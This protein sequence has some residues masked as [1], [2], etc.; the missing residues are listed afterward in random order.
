MTRKVTSK[1]VPDK[2]KTPARTTRTPRTP[3]QAQAPA[4]VKAQAARKVQAS[5]KGQAGKQVKATARQPTLPA[6]PAPTIP[7]RIL[8][9]DIGGTH[10]KIL[11]SGQAVTQARRFDSG[12]GLTPA[13]MVAGVLELAKGWD[14]DAVSL[15]YPGPVLHGQ[16]VREPAN[17]AKGWVGFDYAGA[18]GKPVKIINDA[19]MQALGDYSGGKM[20]FLGLG[21][22][23]GTAL[24][25]DGIVEPLELAHLPYKKRTFEDY[26]GLRGLEKYGRKKWRGLV[27]DVIAT[28]TAAL[29]PETVVLGGGNAKLFAGHLDELP[30]GVS[31]GENTAAFAGGFRLWDDVVNARPIG[32]GEG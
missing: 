4:T 11:L 6:V 28:L 15:G 7:R 32:V 9:V 31:L 2:T 17:L 1:A 27:A 14:F 18:F 12:P 3:A 29:A 21:T 13:Q 23:L 22:G 30:Q 5:G 16:P 20:L 26:V 25:V 19:A 8:S 10:V 24:I